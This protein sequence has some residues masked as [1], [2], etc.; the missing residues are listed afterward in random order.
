MSSP[1][2]SRACMQPWMGMLESTQAGRISEN[3][4]PWCAGRQ[5]QP[6]HP[7]PPPNHATNPLM[8][9]GQLVDCVKDGQMPLRATSH[10]ASHAPGP[11]LAPAQPVCA[12]RCPAIRGARRRAILPSS[13]SD[14]TTP[15]TRIKRDRLNPSTVR[16][17]PATGH[18]PPTTTGR[19]RRRYKA[20]APS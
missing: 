11:L 10:T 9:A 2:G 1:A 15:S 13:C 19:H 18:R 12:D 7:T 20:K 6:Q 3:A 16:R 14:A 5:S 8:T 17:P 4:T